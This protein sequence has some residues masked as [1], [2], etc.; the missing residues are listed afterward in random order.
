[1]ART[2]RSAV[3]VECCPANQQA[4]VAAVVQ[5]RRP[6]TVLLVRG[7]NIAEDELLDLVSK[8]TAISGINFKLLRAEV[9][10]QEKRSRGERLSDA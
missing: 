8:A 6:G 10:R 9:V 4:W 7:C 1:M 3:I 5:H 2:G